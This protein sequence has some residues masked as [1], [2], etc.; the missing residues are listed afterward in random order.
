[1]TNEKLNRANELYQQIDKLQDFLRF[2]LRENNNIIL[3]SKNQK[4]KLLSRSKNIK[5]EREIKLPDCVVVDVRACVKAKIA[6]LKKEYE[7]L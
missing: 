4:F 6:E 5:W 1:M 7:T 2:Y 3:S